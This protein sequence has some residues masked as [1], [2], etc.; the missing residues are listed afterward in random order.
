MI[1]TKH[2]PNSRHHRGR[3]PTLDVDPIARCDSPLVPHFTPH[4]PYSTQGTTFTFAPSTILRIPLHIPVAHS[5][6]GF[7][8]QHPPKIIRMS[9]LASFATP[10]VSL[11]L[12]LSIVVWY[13]YLN[14]TTPLNN[15]SYIAYCNSLANVHFTINVFAFVSFDKE[16]TLVE[17][18][19]LA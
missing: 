6:P 19:A 16:T 9:Y 10:S 5:N 17:E 7:T 13:R 14:P 18:N 11:V 8:R 4:A 15:L 2:G 3:P 12:N 1:A